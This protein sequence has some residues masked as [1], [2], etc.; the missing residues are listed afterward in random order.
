M[1]LGI[2]P[3]MLNPVSWARE[4]KEEAAMANPP[5]LPSLLALFFA[6][7]ST[8]NTEWTSEVV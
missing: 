2:I 7:L 3:G 5:E 1:P 8:T 6:L 4:P